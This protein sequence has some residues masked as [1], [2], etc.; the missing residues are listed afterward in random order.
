MKRL[1]YPL[2]VFAAM[3]MTTSCSQDEELVQQ[4][5]EMTT[6]KVELDGAAKSRTAGDGQTVNELYYA[7]YDKNGDNVIYPA[8]AKYGKTTIT[9]GKATVSL[10]LMKS[11][12]YDIVFWAQNKDANAYTFT[13][14]TEITV[15]YTG[16]K[17]NQENRD[18]FFN[19]LNDYIAKGNTQTVELRRPFAQLNVATSIEDWKNATYLYQANGNDGYPVKSSSVTIDNLATTFNA[20]TGAHTALAQPEGGYNAAAGAE[21]NGIPV[22]VRVGKIGKQK[23]VGA[24]SVLF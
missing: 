4:S 7:V 17:S 3:A 12:A 19:T 6:F 10:P 5:G 23:S 2:F 1:F 13:E 24:E 14:L 9:A 21:V 18:A 20:K 22:A 8:D 11:E 15:N 16:L